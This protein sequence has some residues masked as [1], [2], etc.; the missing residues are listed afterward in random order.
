MPQPD[1]VDLETADALTGRTGKA[2]A[3][4]VPPLPQHAERDEEVVSAGTG[5]PGLAM[6]SWTSLMWRSRNEVSQ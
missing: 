6:T 3:V 2:V 1:R 5:R 4:V